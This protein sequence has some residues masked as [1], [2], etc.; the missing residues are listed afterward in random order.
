MP[1]LLNR[2]CIAEHH[3]EAT[4]SLL[5]CLIEEVDVLG[6]A[7]SVDLRNE[8]EEKQRIA[9]SAPSVFGFVTLP[10]VVAIIHSKTAS[11]VRSISGSYEQIGEHILA[12]RADLGISRLPLP[13]LFEWVSE[14][15]IST[16]S[17]LN[18]LITR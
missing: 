12:G 15:M 16:D 8:N 6:S 14:Q 7:G 13:R 1:N 3:V 5:G 17:A 10:K 18:R 2:L 11:N 4:A 9:L